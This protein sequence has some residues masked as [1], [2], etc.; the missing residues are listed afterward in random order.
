MEEQKEASGLSWPRGKPVWRASCEAIGPALRRTG[1][2]SLL[3]LMMRQHSMPAASGSMSRCTI[4]IRPTWPWGRYSN[5]TV[6]SLIR[7]YQV[8][9]NSPY[10]TLAPSSQETCGALSSK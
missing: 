8:E 10:H 6:G 9:P 7:F 1:S 2:T 3:S 5:G 4:G